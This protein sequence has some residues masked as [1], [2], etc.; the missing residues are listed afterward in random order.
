VTRFLPRVPVWRRVVAL[1]LVVVAVA[2][3]CQEALLPFAIVVGGVAPLLLTSSR[4]VRLPA[5]DPA[6][7][8]ASG[9]SGDVAEIELRR[10]RLIELRRWADGA[11]RRGAQTRTRPRRRVDGWMG[12]P[13]VNRVA[14]ALLAAG[15]L[16]I[17]VTSPA[18]LS[19]AVIGL[20]VAVGL[21]LP[22]Y[23]RPG[24]RHRPLL[25][26]AG[27]EGWEYR[28]A[29]RGL[30]LWWDG[31]PAARGDD[32]RFRDVLW[33]GSHAVSATVRHRS[34]LRQ[35][36]RDPRRAAQHVVAVA[37]P[38]ALPTLLLTPH[39][40]DRAGDRLAP[41]LVTESPDFN[42]HRRVRTDD[43]RTALALLPPHLLERLMAPDLR[44]AGL[45][46]DRESLRAW[47]PGETDIERL[48][49]RV[50][51]VVDVALLIPR[52]VW[53]DHRYDPDDRDRAGEQQR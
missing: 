40:D 29:E 3:G 47:W 10:G 2:M 12:A 21:L 45:C 14:S 1:V 50:A 37:L 11:V 9:A 49:E 27:A 44:E 51:A 7:P 53:Q 42:R 22:R 28:P 5:P 30:R 18:M 19:I 4:S 38:T 34:P 23:V 25:A 15:A 20:I 13:P 32:V 41:D 46:V 43:R 33:Y 31:P 26:W 16:M 39:V 48:P 52:H 35:A 24:R 17:L 36:P 8:W 6:P